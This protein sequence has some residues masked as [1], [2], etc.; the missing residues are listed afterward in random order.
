MNIDKKYIIIFGTLILL[1]I[2]ITG[3]IVYYQEKGNLAG[4]DE[5]FFVPIPEDKEYEIWCHDGIKW[6][7]CAKKVT[8]WPHQLVSISVNLEKF[9]NIPYDSYFLCYYSD[10]SGIG[11]QCF[12]R[13]ASELSGLVLTEEVVP[14][15][16]ETFMLIKIS[17]YPDDNFQGTEE[18]V[19][20]DL[21]GKLI[22]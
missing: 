4:Q 18:I 3:G 16:K 11:K 12:S 20:M 5:Y 21:T 2:I 19:I 7:D 13:I 10:L 1:L 14:E 22:K 6:N 8:F 17:V 15:D 9:D